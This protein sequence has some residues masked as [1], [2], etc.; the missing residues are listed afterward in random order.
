VAAGRSA[1]DAVWDAWKHP[2]LYTMGCYSAARFVFLRA[3][4]ETLKKDSFVQ[5]VGR[6]PLQAL[7]E[8][9]IDTFNFPAGNEMMWIP[10]DWGH[11]E[12]PG[13]TTPLYAGEH[14]IYLGGSKAGDLPT[15]SKAAMFFGHGGKP[16]Q[17]TSLQNWLAQVASWNN[18]TPRI[19]EWR[20]SYKQ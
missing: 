16:A 11:I 7:E 18:A 9:M 6:W 4:A 14:I 10:G 5:R 12:N 13:G 8:V 19:E 20:K 1:Y 15:F 2:N 3:A 17:V